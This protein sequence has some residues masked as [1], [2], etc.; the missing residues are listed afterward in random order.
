MK[1][2]FVK[3]ILVA[4][5]TGFLILSSCAKKSSSTQTRAGAAPRG[6]AAA[7]ATLG[8]TKC[9][10]GVT[11]ATARIFDD[12]AVGNAFR[13]S[14]SDFFS[15]VMADDQLGSLSGASTSTTEGVNMNL[16]IKLVNNQIVKEQ[17]TLDI[18]VM[19]GFANKVNAEST[20][21]LSPITINFTSAESATISATQYTLVFAD[22]YGRITVTGT[23]NA[24][25]TTGTVSFVNTKH[26]NNET[27]KSGNLGKFNFNSCGLLL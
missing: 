2:V 25:N 10:D 27:A 7:A 19:D 17:T 3:T 5:V 18:K 26:Y 8:I 20:E 4:F 1:K 15:A 22:P 21:T 24:T 16:K 6:D 9:A 11:T 13:N 14:W 23:Y 12:A